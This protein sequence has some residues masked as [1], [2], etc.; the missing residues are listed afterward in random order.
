MPRRWEVEISM[1]PSPLEWHG[2]TA[3]R[4]GASRAVSVNFLF[5]CKSRLI[6]RL[7]RFYYCLR[8]DLS[9]APGA[10]C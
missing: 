4:L 2:C 9:P 8:K 5:R 10:L 6:A 1:L 7:G 3:A